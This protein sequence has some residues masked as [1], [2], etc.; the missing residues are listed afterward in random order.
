MPSD[1]VMRLAARLN[2]HSV[3]MMTEE[4]CATNGP[5]GRMNAGLVELMNELEMERLA[6]WEETWSRIWFVVS[7]GSCWRP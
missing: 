5:V 4:R 3:L 2:D 7:L 6:S 1:A